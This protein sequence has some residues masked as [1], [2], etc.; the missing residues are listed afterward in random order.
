VTALHPNARFLVVG[1]TEPDKADAVSR[2]ELEAATAAGVMLIGARRDIERLY[3]AMDV[4]VLASHREGFPRSAMEAAAMGLPVIATNIRGC[5]QVVDD[6]RTGRLVPVENVAS[7]VQA[8]GELV[9][10][11]PQRSVMG[12][13]GRKKALEQFDDRR[14][15]SITLH[16]YKTLMDRVRSRSSGSSDLG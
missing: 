4:F 3:A 10:D 16:I 2:P 7:L 1:P 8:I 15:V 9:V 14:Q 11:R 12:R 13:A 6:G 5:R